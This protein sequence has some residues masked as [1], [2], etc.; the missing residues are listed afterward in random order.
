MEIDLVVQALV[1]NRIKHIEHESLNRIY[2]G[3]L[4]KYGKNVFVKAYKQ[5]QQNK[6]LVEMAVNR[7]LNNRYLGQNRLTTMIDDFS[8][9]LILEDLSLKDLNWPNNEEKLAHEMGRQVAWFHTTVQPVQGMPNTTDLVK[10][11]EASIMTVVSKE[12][13]DALLHI[14]E[15]F[16]DNRHF[17][18]DLKMTESV[19]LHGDVGVRNFKIIENEVVLIDFERARVG[20]KYVDFVKLFYQDF[21]LDPKLIDA[22]KAGYLKIGTLEEISEN[23]KWY[24]IFYTAIGIY[25]YTEKIDDQNFKLI[26]E[27]MFDDCCRFLALT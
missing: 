27:Q 19:V 11:V 21:R 15:K 4:Q 17:W 10:I 25:K 18:N 3:Y 24:A 26:G 2:A 5:G 16:H 14:N 22:F 12:T 8:Y 7:Q 20:I 1:G 13:R 6:F 9:I 23:I